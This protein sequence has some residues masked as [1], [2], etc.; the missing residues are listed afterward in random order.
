MKQTLSFQTEAISVERGD[1]VV[2]NDRFF[3]VN[4]IVS[5]DSATQVTIKPLRWWRVLWYRRGTVVRLVAR[6]LAA[7]A[8][9]G[10]GGFI[11]ALWHSAQSLGG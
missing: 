6:A 8:L 5:V 7:M 11:L 4:E 10:S 2:I 9:G 1:L 3:G